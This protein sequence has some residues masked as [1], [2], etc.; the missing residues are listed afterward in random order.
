MTKI[1]NNTQNTIAKLSH[2]DHDRIHYVISEADLKY[3][4]NIHSLITVQGN[5]SQKN[6]Y[7]KSKGKEYISIDLFEGEILSSHLLD[8]ITNC[9]AGYDQL[10]DVCLFL[11]RVIQEKDKQLAILITSNKDLQRKIDLLSNVNGIINDYEAYLKT[12]AA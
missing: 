8:I 4:W 10:N 1:Q 2:Y 11:M 6:E 3:R 9:S 7:A 12:K 5:I